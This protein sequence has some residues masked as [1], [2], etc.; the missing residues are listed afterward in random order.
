MQGSASF[1]AA[2]GSSKWI[3]SFL[4]KHRND[5]DTTHQAPHNEDSSHETKYLNLYKKTKTELRSIFSSHTKKSSWSELNDAAPFTQNNGTIAQK[6]EIKSTWATIFDTKSGNKLH[7]RA[8]SAPVNNHVAHN[9][10]PIDEVLEEH[11]APM[12]GIFL[13]P[14]PAMMLP[15]KSSREMLQKLKALKGSAH[16][17]NDHDDNKSVSDAGSAITVWPGLED[18]AEEDEEDA[19]SESGTVIIKR[20]A[21]LA[22]LAEEDKESI[23][24]K[25]T[26]NDEDKTTPISEPE[27]AIEPENTPAR[28]SSREIQIECSGALFTEETPG[29]TENVDHDEQEAR[30]A[31]PKEE[32]KSSGRSSLTKSLIQKVFEKAKQGFKNHGGVVEQPVREL[33]RKG[34]LRLS[35]MDKA[36]TSLTS[37]DAH[38]QKSSKASRSSKGSKSSKASR[39]SKAYRSSKAT[40]R[41]HKRG[42]SHST[43]GSNTTVSNYEP[44]VLRLPP[45]DGVFGHMLR[46]FSGPLKNSK[47]KTS[48]DAPVAKSAGKSMDATEVAEP[49]EFDESMGE[50]TPTGAKRQAFDLE[51]ENRDISMQG[52]DETL[53]Y[54]KTR[55]PNKAACHETPKKDSAAPRQEGD[56]AYQGLSPCNFRP[57]NGGSCRRGAPFAADEDMQKAFED[58]QAALARGRQRKL[59]GVAEGD[60]ESEPEEPIEQRQLRELGEDLEQINVE[61]QAT[62]SPAE[63]QAEDNIY[64]DSRA[65]DFADESQ[66]LVFHD[67]D[68]P[69]EGSRAKKSQVEE[70]HAEESQAKALTVD[71]LKAQ[72]HQA[73]EIKSK[74]GPTDVDKSVEPYGP[75]RFWDNTGSGAVREWYQKLVENIDSGVMVRDEAAEKFYDGQESLCSD[76]TTPP[77]ETEVREALHHKDAPKIHDCPPQEAFR[78]I[79]SFKKSIERNTLIRDAFL[80]GVQSTKNVNEM[81]YENYDLATDAA[82]VSEIKKADLKADHRRKKIYKAVTRRYRIGQDRARTVLRESDDVHAYIKMLQ[83]E[84]Q[85]MT[86]E[87]HRAVERLGYPRAE[88]LTDAMDIIYRTIREERLDLSI[89]QPQEEPDFASPESM[90]ALMDEAEYQNLLNNGPQ[91]EEPEP[92]P[93][94]PEDIFF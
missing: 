37:I 51:S 91:D 94:N 50:I 22:D 16:H 89:V 67:D 69:A 77:S 88:N 59:Q 75:N 7:K 80:I 14:N 58:H 64:D 33:R 45:Q 2:L 36:S 27:Q 19:G 11:E 70:S 84:R 30:P 83:Q 35:W 8:K 21:V 90:L 81:I 85:E 87:I 60:D 20:P 44:L 1:P 41:D 53:I 12:L 73:A 79:E 26:T 25:H 38:S 40:R 28:E 32:E 15:Q 10:E 52:L 66:A 55:S 93:E 76:F 4:I 23:A 34:K 17:D 54:K 5:E 42:K 92:E 57:W 46:E 62:N 74:S 65:M 71:G 3:A 56:L 68:V 43:V 49:P 72:E 18:V 63:P 6:K 39:S 13:K 9:L 48:K 78:Q 61:S 86:E 29:N 47:G 24:S 31:V 82:L